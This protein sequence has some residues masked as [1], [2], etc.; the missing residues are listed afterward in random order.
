MTKEKKVNTRLVE[1]H[2]WVGLHADFLFSYAYTR[3]QNEDL[4][5]DL[6]QDTFLAALEKIAQFNGHSSERT[7]LT[8]ILKNKVIDV[9]R[10]KATSLNF[11]PSQSKAAGDE[12]DFFEK[13]NGHWHHRHQ[14]QPFGSEAEDTY[15]EKEFALMLQQCLH[16]LPALWLA[17]FKMKHLD[18]EATEKIC[19]A[20]KVTPAN[21]WVI[22]HRTKLSLRACLQKNWI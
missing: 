15:H 21:F 18:E 1:P 7:W 11:L 3:L 4:A 10:Q 17:V 8:A 5:K 12:P 19:T 20:L 14:P 13:A 16:R 22:M 9:Y 6:V 2:H